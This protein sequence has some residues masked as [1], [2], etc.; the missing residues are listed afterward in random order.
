MRLDVENHHNFAWRE[1]H[2]LADGSERDVI[3]HRKGATPAGLGVL[4]IIP[5]SMAAPGYLV[6]GKGDAASLQSGVPRGGP[7]DEPH[8]REAG[9]HLGATPGASSRSAA[10]RCCRLGS[11]RCR[12]SYKDI[13]TVMAAQASLVDTIARFDPRLVKM[14]PAG[15][16]PED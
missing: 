4:G 10:S 1:R 7:A 5:G 6:R 14:A 16:A 3:V 12:W 15:E 9:I 13:D 8:A 11:T 2:V